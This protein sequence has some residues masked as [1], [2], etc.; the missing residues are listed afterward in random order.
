MTQH[1]DLAQRATTTE[2]QYRSF[3]FDD[4]EIRDDGPTGFTFE[5]VASVVDFAYPVRDALGEYHETIQAGAFNTTLRDKNA[6]ISLYVNHRHADVPLAVRSARASTLEMTADPHLRVKADLD[7][8]RPDVQILA[9]ALRRNEMT[10][11]SIGFMPVKTRDKWNKDWSEVTR[12]Q[13]S[14][15]EASIVEAG[16]NTGGTDATIRSLDEFMTSLADIEMT[17][18]EIRRALLFFQGR[19][20][21][22]EVDTFAARDAEW[23]LRLEKK[24]HAPV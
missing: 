18:D 21:V 19:L 16:A 9:S 5:G 15:R 3:S 6:A 12:T 8:S 22:V 1:R 13:V 14:L 7:P 17:E 24:R 2:L 20:P 23:R 4:I 11:M 10:E